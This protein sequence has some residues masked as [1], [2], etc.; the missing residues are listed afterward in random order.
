MGRTLP[1]HAGGAQNVGGKTLKA[2]EAHKDDQQKR[3]KQSNAIR[4]QRPASSYRNGTPVVD[5]TEDSDGMDIDEPADYGQGSSKT[6]HRNLRRATSRFSRSSCGQNM[7]PPP[8]KSG[9]TDR[10]D[11]QRGRNYREIPDHANGHESGTL[12]DGPSRSIHNHASGNRKFINSA[13]GSY[14]TFNTLAGPVLVD[15]GMKLNIG[16]I[17]ADGPAHVF[18][19]DH[20]RAVVAASGSSGLQLQRIVEVLHA[21]ARDLGMI[22]LQA[23]LESSCAKPGAPSRPASL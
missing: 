16:H 6:H 20:M 23:P 15:E 12:H 17:I 19:Q 9:D 2:W 1:N 22:W 13:P 5:L 14:E 11:G 18:H 7:S 4:K 10:E 8:S 3:A 21:Q